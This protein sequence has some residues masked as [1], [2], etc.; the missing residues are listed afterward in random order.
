MTSEIQNNEE[1]TTPQES[2]R[3]RLRT[4]TLLELGEQKELLEQMQQ[5]PP[6]PSN[7]IPKPLTEA[8]KHCYTST[9]L[10]AMAQLPED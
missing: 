5:S 7:P 6:M 9:I 8:Q 1:A 4:A 10:A 3:P 2:P